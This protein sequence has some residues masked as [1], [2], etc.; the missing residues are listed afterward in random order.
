M[1]RERGSSSRAIRLLLGLL[2]ISGP[3]RAR[4]KPVHY[5]YFYPWR[6]N[7]SS[8]STPNA[9]LPPGSPDFMLPEVLDNRARSSV[10]IS[11]ADLYPA[12]QFARPMHDQRAKAAAEN[13]GFQDSLPNQVTVSEMSCQNDVD[14]LYFRATL[15]FLKNLAHPIIENAGSSSCKVLQ[16]QNEYRIS[17]GK[18]EFWNCGVVDCSTGSD[19]SFCLRVR[20]PTIAGLRL[21]DDLTVTLQCRAQRSV[22]SHTR[23]VI[24]NAIDTSARTAPRV[25]AGGHKSAFETELTLHRRTPGSEQFDSKIEAGG[26]VVLGEEILLR[27][28]VRD[29]DGWKYAKM[30]EV[31]MHHHVGSRQRDKATSSLWVLD[32][33]GCLNSQLPGIGLGEQYRVGPLESYL[34]FRAFM[35]DSAQE[36]DEIALT[37]KITGCLRGEDCVFNCP[38]AHVRKAQETA[39]GKRQLR[40]SNRTIDWQNDV[41]FKVAASSGP[42][43]RISAS[44][45]LLLYFLTAL[46]ILSLISLL[47]IVCVFTRKSKRFYTE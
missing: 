15:S 4:A 6:Q 22:A 26:T 12:Y 37:V 41:T 21:K 36:T 46:L 8:V 9:Y 3:V 39:R 31:T 19:R 40:A 24:L 13:H 7:A 32:D 43:R 44:Q 5:D 34:L 38:A 20:F 27:A 35:F 1:S 29:G 10:P 45:T 16:F 28:A 30:S 17:F 42:N 14:E 33:E 23:R 47:C 2:Q 25:A 11:S 18:D